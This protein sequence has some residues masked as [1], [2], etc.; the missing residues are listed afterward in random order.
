MKLL[1]AFTLGADGG[2]GHY[3][4]LRTAA[5]TTR[6]ASPGNSASQLPLSRVKQL[7]G[8]LVRESWGPAGRPSRGSVRVEVLGGCGVEEPAELL[9]LV[10]CY[11]FV[12]LRVDCGVGDGGCVE[13][14]VLGVDR[15]AQV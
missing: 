13:H 6:R 4:L 7:A 15:G 8:F 1:F 2:F 10:G 9:D 5:N 14:G 3:V 11:A 12:G